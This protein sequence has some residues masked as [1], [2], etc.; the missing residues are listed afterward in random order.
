MT[1]VKNRLLNISCCTYR[2]SGLRQSIRL[3]RK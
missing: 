1:A 3:H 2:L